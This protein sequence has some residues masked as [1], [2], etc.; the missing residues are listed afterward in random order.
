M[1]ENMRLI[2]KWGKPLSFLIVFL[3]SVLM[4]NGVSNAVYEYDKKHVLILHSYHE[5]FTWTQEVNDGLISTLKNGYFNLDISVEYLDWKEYPYQENLDT[6]LQLYAYKY[7]NQPIDVIVTT[8]DAALDFAFKNREEVFSNAPI[9]FCGVNEVGRKTITEGYTDY[10]G[11][12]E[13]VDIEETIKLAIETIPG[14]ERIYMVYDN[15]ESGF[16]TGQLALDILNRMNTE[17][18]GLSINGVT[19]EELL[20]AVA[21]VPKNS[22]I[23]ILSFYSDTT[24]RTLSF[25][26]LCQVTSEVSKVPIFNLYDFTIG[27]GAIGG[28]V[29]SGKLHGEKAAELAIRILNGEKSVDVPVSYEKTSRKLYDYHQLIRFKIPLNRIDE[30]SE[31]LNKPFSFFETYKVIVLIASGVFIMLTA[32]IFVLVIYIRRLKKAEKELQESH[33]ELSQLYVELAVSREEI[34]EHC[35]ELAASQEKLKE[36]EE[37]YRLVL[38]GSNDMIWDMDLVGKKYFFSDRWFDLMGYDKDEEHSFFDWKELVHP[39]DLSL[40]K[41]A[42]LDHLKGRTPYYSCEYRLRCKNG[43]YKWFLSRGKALYNGKGR[44]TRIAGSLTDID[45]RKKS[46]LKLQESYQE[47]EATYEQLFATQAELNSKYEEMKVIQDKLHHN[48]YHDALTELPN[49][50]SLYEHTLAYMNKSADDRS[51]F[52]YIDSDNFKFIN[53]TMGHSFGDQFIVEIGKRLSSML[54]EKQT[55]Y[56]LGGDEFII[57][58][59]GYDRFEDVEDFAAEII[60][61]FNLPFLIGD[62]TLYATVSI[63]ISMYPEHGTSADELL[64][65]ADLAMYRAKSLGKNS[66]YVYNSYLQTIVKDRMSIERNLRGALNNNEFLLYYQPQLNIETGEISG[67]EALIRWNN[68]ELGMVSPLKFINIAEETHLI[69]AIGEWVLRSACLFLKKLH[70]MGFNSLNISVNVSIL[71]LLQ[72]DFVEAVQNTIKEVGLEPGCVELEI[73]ESVLMQSYQAISDKLHQLKATGIKLALDDFGQGYSSLSYLKQ[74]P[75]DTLKIDKSFID[76][77]KSKNPKDNF[78]DT[79]VMIGRKMGLVVLAEGVEYKE[80]MDY[81][82]KHKCHKVQGYLISRPVPETDAIKLYEEWKAGKE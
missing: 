34:E 56:R 32:F 64:Q 77:I 66:F 68:P 35:N 59:R 48:A 47:L 26:E 49:R 81:L 65:H 12:I 20:D 9:V 62:S 8:D 58:Y 76:S 41:K 51:A 55:I 27:Y 36:S 18:Q 4:V 3:L 50:L 61:R 40:A 43:E 71:Q 1:G 72:E 75:I 46:E 57:N 63:G 31:I 79:I 22:A 14:L 19:Y 44:A 60:R 73:T 74:L 70:D 30:D 15:T 5:G 53:D 25:E 80:Q 42:S 38:D 28:S 29:L 11:I 13:Q 7:R 2:E 67:F 33:S 17:V 54:N 45:D 69:I 52:L 24:G 10:T 78:I 23:Y 16:S 39:D 6:L 21:N 37:R 82:I